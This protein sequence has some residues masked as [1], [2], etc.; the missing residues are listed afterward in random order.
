MFL[1]RLGRGRP[2]AVPQALYGSTASP[3]RYCVAAAGAVARQAVGAGGHIT[4]T[5]NFTG[6]PSSALMQWGW[7]ASK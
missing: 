7:V 3:C 6:L 5:R 2:L 1:C 4:T